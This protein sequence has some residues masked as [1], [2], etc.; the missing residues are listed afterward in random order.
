MVATSGSHGLLRE[1]I[2]I[3]HLMSLFGADP[4]PFI[5]GPARAV[6][7]GD[8]LS[9][10]CGTNLLSNPRPSIAWIT[11]SGTPSESLNSRITS[12]INDTV[13]ELNY[14][15]LEDNG[16]WSCFLLVE[17]TDVLGPGGT[18]SPRITVWEQTVFIDV[19]VVGETMHV[20]WHTILGL[21]GPRHF[22]QNITCK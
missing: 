3:H 20:S 19:A 13:L 8:R 5:P 16:V 7:L 1:W 17:G 22:P 9:L 12:I 14:T 4:P 21:R 18:V 6:A 10:A 11:P 2:A 15:T